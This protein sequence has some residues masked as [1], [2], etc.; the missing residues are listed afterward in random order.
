MG[1]EQVGLQLEEVVRKVDRVEHGYAKA[2]RSEFLVWRDSGIYHQLAREVSLKEGEVHV[3]F[4]TGLGFFPGLVKNANPNA[5]VIGVDRN[6]HMI[7]NGARLLERDGG[8]VDVFHSEAVLKLRDGVFRNVH[9]LDLEAESE[10][11]RAVDSAKV[12][13]G[14]ES[15]PFAESVEKCVAVDPNVKLVVDDVRTLVYTRELLNGAN[16][17]SASLMFT[18]GSGRSVVDGVVGKVGCRKI[19]YSA[20]ECREAI[21]KNVGDLINGSFELLSERME[22]GGRVVWTDRFSVAAV[23]KDGSPSDLLIASLVDRLGPQAVYWDLEKCFVGLEMDK[24]EGAIQWTSYAAKDS[25]VEK[26]RVLSFCFQRNDRP[27]ASVA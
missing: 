4:G 13:A 25:D 17:Q 10:R 18:G 5:V 7:L 16:I 22:V 24:P 15:V 12:E 6:I 19:H 3:D 21:V 2:Y 23:N 8:A 1:V 9:A 27:Y 14:R 20:E 26:L 11:L